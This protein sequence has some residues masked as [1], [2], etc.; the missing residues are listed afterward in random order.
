MDAVVAAIDA[1]AAPATI[2]ICSAAFAAVL[3]IIT[4]ADPSFVRSGAP[5]SVLITMQGA[6]KSGVAIA[7]GSAAVA[8]IK[9]GGGNVIANG[10]T[11]GTTTLFD[12]TLNT[13]SITN[14]QTVTM[15]SGTITHSP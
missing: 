3:C 15:S 1:N 13:T 5:P 7:N 2:E 6:P 12:V 14:G 8:R 11:V 4:L 9:D 10:L